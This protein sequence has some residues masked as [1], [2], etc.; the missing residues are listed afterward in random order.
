M[1][2]LLADGSDGARETDVNALIVEL[3]G[4]LREFSEQVDAAAKRTSDLDDDITQRLSY[5]PNLPHESVPD[6]ASEE[7]N[8]V[9][10]GVG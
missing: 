8:V 6:G 3:Q 4:T 1:A 2:D 7:D 9:D 10:T 5:L